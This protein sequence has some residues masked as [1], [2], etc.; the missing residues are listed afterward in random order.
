MKPLTAVIISAV[1]GSLKAAC[2]VPSICEV[3]EAYVGGSTRD[4]NGEVTAVSCIR[5]ESLDSYLISPIHSDLDINNPQ[6]GC[7]FLNET[8]RESA[9]TESKF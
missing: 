8:R 5:H 7:N 4:T 1:C 3:T 6:R 2:M 9:I